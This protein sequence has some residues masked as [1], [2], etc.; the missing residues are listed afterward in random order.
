V[1]S[2]EERE[3]VV[4][5]CRLKGKGDNRPT[6]RGEHGRESGEIEGVGWAS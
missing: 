3:K 4:V 5:W 2:F 1:E 6:Y